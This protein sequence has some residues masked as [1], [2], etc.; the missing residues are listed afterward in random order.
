VDSALKSPRKID[1]VG[2]INYHVSEMKPLNV[3][4]RAGTPVA[5]ARDKRLALAVMT[6][7][8]AV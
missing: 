6:A 8:R 1:P 7:H 4:A 3:C 5:I 2:E